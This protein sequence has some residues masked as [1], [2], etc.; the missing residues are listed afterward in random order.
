MLISDLV[1]GINNSLNCCSEDIASLNQTIND[2]NI[3]LKL[4]ERHNHNTEEI[5]YSIRDAVIVT[6]AS[7]R[8]LLANQAAG[9]LFGFDSRGY[10]A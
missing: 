9:N 2:L 5:I 6:D 4:L 10:Q 1:Q 3:H 7:E 8:I